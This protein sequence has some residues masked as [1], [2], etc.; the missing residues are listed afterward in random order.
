[1]NIGVLLLAAGSGSRFGG[2]IPK[3]YVEVQGKAL[4]LY[5]LEHLAAAQQISVVQP[6]VS[7]GDT[8]FSRLV[9]GHSFPFRLLEP[10]VGG[11]ARSISMRRGL[12]A[13]PADIDL[14]AVH[15]AARP[16]PSARLLADVFA[17]AELHG[18]AVP[19]VPVNDT[20]KRVDEH[21]KVMETPARDLLRAVQTPQVARRAWFER[22]IE[23]ESE[24]LHLH[25]D[26]A[27]LLE[28]AGFDVY[29]SRGDVNNRK[30]TTPEDILWLE[31]QLKQ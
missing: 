20:I 16:L 7:E 21:G 25:T 3:Q 14:V 24:R 18:A 30:I 12:E 29:V 5:T 19:G 22:A 27:S 1:M 17:M 28:A 15:D 31:A 13:M 9:A 2:V 6:V 23:I 26:D 10:V 8:T 4:L 11:S